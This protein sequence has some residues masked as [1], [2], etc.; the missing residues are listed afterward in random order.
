MGEDLESVKDPNDAKRKLEE[1]DTSDD[2]GEMKPPAN[3]KSLG[4]RREQAK[5]DRVEA[6]RIS[7]LRKK[8]EKEVASYA[9]HEAKVRRKQIDELEREAA[10]FE[11]LAEDRLQFLREIQEE[12][13]AKKR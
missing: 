7:E 13:D 4:E 11:T 10:D 5:I 8:I 1:E 6:Q 2:R 9:H 12:V 3:K